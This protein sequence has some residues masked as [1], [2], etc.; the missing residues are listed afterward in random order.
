MTVSS[1]TARIERAEEIGDAQEHLVS[2]AARLGLGGLERVLVVGQTNRLVRSSRRA[3]TPGG[4][5]VAFVKSASASFAPSIGHRGRPAKF[6][7]RR[8][9]FLNTVPLRR[10]S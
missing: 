3:L 6:A 7:R 9:A 8:S 1:T 10:A 5:L 4:M 2:T